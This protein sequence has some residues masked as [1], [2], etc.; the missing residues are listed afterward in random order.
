MVRNGGFHFNFTE[1][2]FMLCEGEDDKD[3]LESI[4][5][6]RGLPKYQVCC[7]AECNPQEIGG[8]HGFASSLTGIEPLTGFPAL[9][10]LV[11]ATDN[12][13][14][15]KSFARAQ[16]AIS[17]NGGTPPNAPGEIGQL[18]G[19]PI[20]ILLIP[21]GDIE[22]NLELLCLPAIQEKWPEA[23]DCVDAFLSCTK[24]DSWKNQGNFYKARARSYVIG[25]NEDDPYKGLGY[26]FKRGT[27]SANHACFNKLAE[28]IKELEAKI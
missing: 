26:L 22:G 8:W 3:V 20:T 18:A 27:L 13:I 21:S 6:D 7:A 4:L 10:V 23:I 14:S 1:T 24:A 19:K 5:R 15:G 17:D 9:K 28:F 16:E 25:K 12:D 11:I 2:R